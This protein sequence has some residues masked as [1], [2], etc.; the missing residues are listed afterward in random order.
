M[1]STY[2]RTSYP[3]PV[4]RAPPASPSLPQSHC[5][6]YHERSCVKA[7]GSQPRRLTH[8][9]WSLREFSKSVIDDL[10]G[11]YGELHSLGKGRRPRQGTPMRLLGKTVI[12]K[13]YPDYIP[14]VAGRPNKPGRK[15][16]TVCINTTRRA[17]KRTD[18][19]TLCAE[20]RV[21]LCMV[22]CFREYHT[23]KD[24]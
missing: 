8:N 14:S 16:C 7:R 17:R 13:H 19:Q 23:L 11:Q 24:F 3:L 15:R 9:T 20:C 18:V 10:I 12:E 22:P 6:C 4:G 21:P 2:E 5:T 1:S